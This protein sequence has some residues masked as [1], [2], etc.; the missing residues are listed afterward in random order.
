MYGASLWPVMV[1]VAVTCCRVNW[2]VNFV[3]LLYTTCAVP[4]YVFDEELV[5]GDTVSC[6]R[7]L[8]AV[9]VLTPLFGERMYVGVVK[10][11][12]FFARVVLVVILF[13]ARIVNVS[14]VM[15]V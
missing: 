10:R 4:R 9:V 6:V 12:Y 1:S 15:L 2:W 3:L 7:L 8:Y 14:L 11:G 5:V 13:C